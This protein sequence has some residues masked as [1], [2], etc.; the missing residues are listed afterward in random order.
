MHPDSQESK[1]K[2]KVFMITELK[3]TKGGWPFGATKNL[4]CVVGVECLH[5]HLKAVA[6]KDVRHEAEE[7]QTLVK[8]Q[9]AKLTLSGP[10]VREVKLRILQTKLSKEGQRVW[11]LIHDFGGLFRR[12]EDSYP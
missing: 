12:N 9:T 4:R 10:D 2:R 8:G 7:P 3:W 5:K 1:N 11:Q 6:R